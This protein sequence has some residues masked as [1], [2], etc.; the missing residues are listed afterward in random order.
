M[1]PDEADPQHE[2]CVGLWLSE[3]DKGLIIIT[4]YSSSRGEFMLVVAFDQLR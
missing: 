1:K 2:L 4:E 3:S